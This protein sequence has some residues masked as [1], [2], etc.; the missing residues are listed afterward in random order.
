MFCS[1]RLFCVF[2]QKERERLSSTDFHSMAEWIDLSSLSPFFTSPLQV[3]K[4][5]LS[6]SW[7]NEDGDDSSGMERK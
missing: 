5:F 7:Y 3:L 4:R 2:F 1:A 6:P